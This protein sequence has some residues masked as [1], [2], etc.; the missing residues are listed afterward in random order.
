V[1]VNRRKARTEADALEVLVA[2]IELLRHENP[3]DVSVSIVPHKD[4]KF[5]KSLNKRLIDMGS[6]CIALQNQLHSR[7]IDS[8]RE[9]SDDAE[10]ERRANRARTCLAEIAEARGNLMGHN[11]ASIEKME[12]EDIEILRR[13][14]CSVENHG[15][16]LTNK[17]FYHSVGIGPWH[18]SDETMALFEKLAFIGRD[19]SSGYKI[20]LEGRPES[21][22]ENRVHELREMAKT[23]VEKKDEATATTTKAAAK[24][25]EKKKTPAAAED[26]AQKKAQPISEEKNVGAK[27]TAGRE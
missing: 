26:K 2:A 13:E 25:A 15:V 20:K 9:G 17:A 8:T 14:V 27:R 6:P 3:N 4:K 5:F 16:P 10:R 7:G 1:G 19:G 12:D 24:A 21:A 18:H 11:S 22:I 23:D